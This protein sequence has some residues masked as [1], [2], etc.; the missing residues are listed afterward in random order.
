MTKEKETLKTAAARGGDGGG[1]SQTK[2]TVVASRGPAATQARVS[3]T[4]CDQLTHSSG[5]STFEEAM[6]FLVFA[7]EIVVLFVSEEMSSLTTRMNISERGVN[8]RNEKMNNRNK[9]SGQSVCAGVCVT[10]YRR[11]SNPPSST[12][13]QP[14]LL[15]HLLC[16]CFLQDTC[17]ALHLYSEPH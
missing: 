4:D 12:F 1:T 2:K 10:H 17:H 5:F 16:W 11:Y 7:K 8:I 6:L 14:D 13:R 15:L 9:P 3:C